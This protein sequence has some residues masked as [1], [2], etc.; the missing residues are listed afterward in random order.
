MKALLRGKQPLLPGDGLGAL[1]LGM[2]RAEVHSLF[3]TGEEDGKQERFCRGE[4]LVEYRAGRVSF[5]EAS[6]GG[7][8]KPQLFTTGVFQTSAKRLLALL[9]RRGAKVR[10][11]EPGTLYVFPELQ[12]ALWRED[13][14]ERIR[15]ELEHLN[16]TDPEDRASMR[17]LK[18]DIRRFQSFQTVAT[19]VKDYYGKPNRRPKKAASES[20]FSLM[21]KG[22]ISLSR[23]RNETV[24]TSLETIVSH[25]R[26]W[27][28][29]V[30]RE[31]RQY[32]DGLRKK[33]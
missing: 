26:D 25:P 13:D 31:A 30:V 17:V 19:F 27:K 9:G 18:A 32:L 4:V 1:R 6:A 22:A 2:T 11:E 20:P 7:N 8:V 16:A 5:I 14:P 12:I 24:L 29:S 23:K 28:A 15:E 3:G 10:Q 33:T 21:L